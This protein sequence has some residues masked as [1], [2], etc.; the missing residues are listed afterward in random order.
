[1]A[2]H[3][4]L[5]ERRGPMD[6][7][8]APSVTQAP[9]APVFRVAMLAPLSRQSPGSP[10]ASPAVPPPTPRAGPRLQGHPALSNFGPPTAELATAA[11]TGSPADATFTEFEGGPTAEPQATEPARPLGDGGRSGGGPGAD[12]VA[13]MHQRLAAAAGRCYPQAA[14]RFRQ[15]GSV[16]MSF[17]VD[18]GGFPTQ[19]QVTEPSGLEL[20]D[21]AARDCVVPGAS[22]FPQSAAGTCFTVPVR[23][24]QAR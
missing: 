7:V 20:L 3:A 5:G 17:C 18:L 13:A 1:M 15:Q 23:F 10:E 9:S 12:V 4:T 19:V 8:R 11:G 21:A 24:G 2:L 16:G 22:P 14:R 6:Q